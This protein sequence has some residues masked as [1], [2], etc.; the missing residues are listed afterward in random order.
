MSHRHSAEIEQELKRTVTFVPHLVPLDRGILETIY[1]SLRKGVSE[2]DVAQAME[3]AYAETPF[4]RLTTTP[5][6]IKH[7][8]HTNF[9]D[10]GWTVDEPTQRLV[11]VSVLDNLLK[12]A[13]GQ[14]VQNLNLVLGIDER[15]GLL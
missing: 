6:E 5:P 13:A 14:A 2:A 8:A 15:T 10:I 12:G 4:V 7:V 1:V 9:C 3:T 11:V